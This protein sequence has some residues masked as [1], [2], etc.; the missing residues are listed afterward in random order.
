MILSQAIASGVSPAGHISQ[1]KPSGDTLALFKGIKG[2]IVAADVFFTTL[3]AFIAKKKAAGTK[4]V[5]KA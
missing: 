5:K 4:A 3:I 1:P 2:I